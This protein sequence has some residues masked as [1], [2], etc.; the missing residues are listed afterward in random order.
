[1]RVRSR[2]EAVE[3]YGHIDF[4]SKYWSEQSTWLKLVRIPDGMFPNW[5]VLDTE[6]PVKRIAMNIDLHKPFLA[7]LERVAFKGLGK[8]LKTFDGCFN[9]RM[10][11]GSNNQF[12]A[13]SYGLAIDL[14]AEENKLGQF[15]TK[16]SPDFIECFT[17]LGWTWGGNF[18]TR[19]DPMHF[20]MCWE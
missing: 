4:A 13:H 17:Q 8:E 20:S 9:I 5:K 15:W 16:F 12:S 11:R 3:R 1:M 14:N 19:K 2:E 6:L 10:V 7:A 18:K